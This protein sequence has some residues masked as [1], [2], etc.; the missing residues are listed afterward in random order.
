MK[1][2]I[3]TD[4]KTNDTVVPMLKYMRLARLLGRGWFHRDMYLKVETEDGKNCHLEQARLAVLMFNELSGINRVNRQTFVENHQAKHDIDACMHNV[5]VQLCE[6]ACILKMSLSLSLSGML[7]ACF[8][9]A[10]AF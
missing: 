8:W 10:H 5:E 4:M 2:E 9:L 1:Q 7:R 3:W 6:C